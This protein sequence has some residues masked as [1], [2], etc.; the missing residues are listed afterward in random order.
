MAGPSA[1]LGRT[2]RAPYK[3]YALMKYAE[4]IKRWIA[5]QPDLTLLE[6]GARLRLLRCYTFCVASGL[7]RG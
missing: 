1:A 3:D 6:L 5:I 7:T 4:R 2:S